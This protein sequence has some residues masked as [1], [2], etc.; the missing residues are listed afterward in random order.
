[1]TAGSDN[2]HSP[3]KQVF[4]VELEEKLTDISDYVRLILSHWPI[5]LHVP[6]ERFVMPDEPIDERHI[7]YWVNEKEETVPLEAGP[8]R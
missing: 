6:P 8:W 4:G 7:A 1:M 5:G 3:A 2:H